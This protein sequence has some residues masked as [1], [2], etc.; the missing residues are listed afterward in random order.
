VS[1]LDEANASVQHCRVEPCQLEVSV[2]RD[3]SARVVEV[4]GEVDA[5]N[6]DAFGEYLRSCVCG[7][8]PLVVDMTAVEFFGVQGIVKLFEI[9][10][11][12]RRAGVDW[13]LVAGDWVGHLLR[14]A[15]RDKV[16]PT[17]ESRN[18]AI[19]R[20]ELRSHVGWLER[21]LLDH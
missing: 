8:R 11:Q 7:E 1:V 18:D 6:S 14:I 13:E 9:D 15:D 3:G 5:T 17:A 20:I 21:L 10:D 2:C 19:H 12:C 16:L 4:G